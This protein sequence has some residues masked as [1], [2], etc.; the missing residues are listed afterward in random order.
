[1]PNPITTER[2]SFSAAALASGASPKAIR[3]WLDKGQVLLQ[4]N[5]SREPGRWRR[6]SVWDV[7]RLAIVKRLVDFCLP[8][9]LASQWAGGVLTPM[10]RALTFKNTPPAAL[11]AGLANTILVVWRDGEAWDGQVIRVPGLEPKAIPDSYVTVDVA[12]IAAD[13][14]AALEDIHDE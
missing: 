9:E 6:F 7:L 1:M 8:V 3:N 12:R 11:A 5:E 10:N 4:A 14:V 2:Y 13:V